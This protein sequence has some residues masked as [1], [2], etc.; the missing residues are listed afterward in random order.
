MRDQVKQIYESL[1]ENEMYQKRQKM[2]HMQLH[3][4]NFDIYHI[5]LQRRQLNIQDE[6]HMSTR[7]MK[8]KTKYSSRIT[9]K[10]PRRMN[11]WQPL[12]ATETSNRKKKMLKRP[13]LAL[14]LRK[15]TKE[16]L[17]D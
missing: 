5:Y 1:K 13:L 17:V 15:T 12:T 16:E 10:Q 7:A 6:E 9:L 4:N 11:R 14:A 8:R 3:E 2:I